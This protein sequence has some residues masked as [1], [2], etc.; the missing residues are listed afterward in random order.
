MGAVN[1]ILIV[2][3]IR[4]MVTHNNSEETTK[5]HWPSLMAV[6][7]A[8]GS[9]LPPFEASKASS[10]ISDLELGCVVCSLIL[11]SSS[12]SCRRNQVRPLPLLLLRQRSEHSGSGPVGGPQ[13][14]SAHQWLW[15]PDGEHAKSGRDVTRRG[16]RLTPFLARPRAQSAGGAKLKWWLDPVSSPSLQL[17]VTELSFTGVERQPS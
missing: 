10:S 11:S 15:Y 2:E 6:G 16:R 7:I 4:T 17:R 12:C 13:E 14:R 5:L 9:S 8:F 1:L 3:S